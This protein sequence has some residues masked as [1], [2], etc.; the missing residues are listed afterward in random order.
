VESIVDELQRAVDE[1]LGRASGPMHLRLIMQPIVAS[2]LATRAGLRDARTGGSPF[3]WTFLTVPGERKRLL[4]SAWKDIGKV[5]VVAI[6]LDTVYQ[7]IVLHA[8]R[9]LQTL[10]VAVILAVLPYVLLRGPVT[11]IA[12]GARRERAVAP[13]PD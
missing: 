8:F 1:L 6:L 4:G 7:I 13:K 5:F 2:I 11:R 10:I 3:F 12:R 9:P